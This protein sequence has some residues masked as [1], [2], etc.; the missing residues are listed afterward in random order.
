MRKW[1]T[2]ELE[3]LQTNWEE[4]SVKSIASN[5][6]RTEAA[7]ILKAHSIGLRRKIQSPIGDN[8]RRLINSGKTVREIA[9]IVGC[10]ERYVYNFKERTGMP[11]NRN[12]TTAQ[13]AGMRT[14]LANGYSIKEIHAKY[15]EFCRSTVW[16]HAN[17]L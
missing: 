1:Q 10:S 14:M 8:I 3:Y 15:P 11:K 4:M 16:R 7:I 6:H 9:G 12:I 13:R 2:D 5:L 17:G